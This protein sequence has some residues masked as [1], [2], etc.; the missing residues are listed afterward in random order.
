MGH[1]N[2]LAGL[3]SQERSTE[4]N[5]ANVAAA[6]AQTRH[7]SLIESARRCSIREHAPPD[8][9]TLNQV[10]E[11]ELNDEADATEKG[12]VERGLEICR[13]DG[14][15]AVGLHALQQVADFDVRV[16]VMA[17]LHFAAFA[18]ERISLV[19]QQ[20]DATFFCGVEDAS[21]V[22]F[23]FADVLADRGRQI[24]AVQI[25]P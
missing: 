19:E 21:Q 3:G 20:D 10:R 13:Q 16:A 17:I 8:F 1:A 12:G 23:G 11:R 9:G 15:A 2:R 24:D 18:E 4:R 6:H 14:Q 7:L 22:L 25:E 5:V